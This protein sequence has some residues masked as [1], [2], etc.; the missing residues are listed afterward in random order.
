MQRPLR[1]KAAPPPRLC[2]SEQ[3]H[4]LT[5]TQ[6]KK[7]YRGSAVMAPRLPGLGGGGGRSRPL[8]PTTEENSRRWPAGYV[9]TRRSENPGPARRAKTSACTRD[10]P[11]K[12]GREEE[13]RLQPPLRPCPSSRGR[14]AW[15]CPCPRARP[16]QSRRRGPCGGPEAPKRRR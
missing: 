13:S 15:P 5:G 9:P 12:S 10:P 8:V 7:S 16:R 4:V 14:R 2:L 3:Q 6:E 1:R 11:E